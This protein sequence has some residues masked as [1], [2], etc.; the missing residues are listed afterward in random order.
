MAKKI[1]QKKKQIKEI[2]YLNQIITTL[3]F[4]FI[5][6]FSIVRIN[7]EDDIFW[8]MQTGKYILET[9]S[10]PSTD[11]FGYITQGEKWIPFEWLWDT[12]AYLVYSAAG[13]IGLYFVNAILLVL[14][15]FVI[16]IEYKLLLI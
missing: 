5:V 8:H 9:K 2:K 14:I 1:Q 12:S 7:G 6:L 16:L 11:V 10:V 4:V 3:F 15:F 13:F